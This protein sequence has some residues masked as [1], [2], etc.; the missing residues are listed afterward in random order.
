MY[1]VE[2]KQSKELFTYKV[3]DSV[4]IDNSLVT[5]FE[6]VWAYSWDEGLSELNDNGLQ[7]II[8]D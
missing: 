1:A 2:E 5:H 6:Y 8:P 7:V 4:N 3:I